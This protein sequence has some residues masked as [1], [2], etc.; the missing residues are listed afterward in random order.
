MHATEQTCVIACL[1]RMMDFMSWFGAN[2]WWRGLSNLDLAGAFGALVKH[3]ELRS[4]Q[5]WSHRAESLAKRVCKE[6]F[7]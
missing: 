4:L 1:P 2:K 5:A 7:A 3:M 6:L